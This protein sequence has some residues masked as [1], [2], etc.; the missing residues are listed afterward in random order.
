[1]RTSAVALS[2]FANAHHH[3]RV[4]Q[5]DRQIAAWREERDRKIDFRWHRKLNGHYYHGE[6]KRLHLNQQI[7]TAKKLQERLQLEIH[8][9]DERNRLPEAQA[10]LDAL[11][12]RDPNRMRLL[13]S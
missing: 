13:R 12:E 2:F 3:M 6:A 1:M 4:R 7:V 8:E 11:L 5:L 10:Q 9:Q